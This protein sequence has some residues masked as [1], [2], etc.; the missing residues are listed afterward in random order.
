M[1]ITT[2]ALYTSPKSAIPAPSA[3]V[4]T[5]AL[6]GIV[7][8]IWFT[9]LVVI[10]GF[11]Q[12]DYSHVRLPISAL[13]AWP[14]GWIQNINFFVFGSL[15]MVYAFSLHRGVQHTRR[16]SIGFGLLLLSGLGILLAGVFPWRMVDGVPTEN[17]PHVVAAI[18]AFASTALGL[19][20]F[21]RRM[22]A[23][24]RWRDLATYTMFTGIIMLTLFLVLGRFA[25]D[26]GAP[27]HLWAGL[28]QRIVCGVWFANMIGLAVRLRSV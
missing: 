16:G 28:I 8:P 23:D 13:A 17:P 1:T 24:P 25:I 12:A 22:I 18:M 10:Q 3:R 4:R 26:D 5:L 15:T 20:V 27:L 6:A 11:L 19:M 9:T 2:Q 14:T 21:A 7:G